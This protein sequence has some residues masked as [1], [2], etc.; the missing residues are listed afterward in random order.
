MITIQPLDASDTDEFRS[1]F[2]EVFGADLSLAMVDWKYGEGRGLQ[3]GAFSNENRMVAH[4]GI[5]F[6]DAL[7][8]HRHYRI[9]QIGDQFGVRNKPG[10]LAR[11]SSVFGSLLGHV[12]E[13]ISSREN[14]D[15]MVYGFPSTPVVGLIKRLGFGASLNVIHELSFLPDNNSD[16]LSKGVFSANRR[17][18]VR[19]NQFDQAFQKQVARMW[20]DMAN[21]FGGGALGV[22]D[23][24]YLKFRYIEHPEHQYEIYRVT[25]WFGRTLGLAICR[26]IGTELELMDLIASLEH[27]SLCITTLKSNLSVMGISILKMWLL[28]RHASHFSSL[29]ATVVPLQ[30]DLMVN[31]NS[32]GGDL[33]RFKDRWWLTSGDADY[34]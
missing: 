24:G 34:R 8:E 27:M 7:V 29:A 2:R 16:T 32:A 9:A 18:L 3:F 22:R 13:Q 19:V 31:H 20:R 33:E 4:C 25:G 1:I 26:R 15:A 21:D 23:A 11:R 30:F 28:D 12:L 10:G 5:T 17:K 6:R 14:P